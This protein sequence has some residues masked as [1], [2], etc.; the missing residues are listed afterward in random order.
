VN[1]KTLSVR[2]GGCTVGGLL[3]AEVLVL[4]TLG[5]GHLGLVLSNG[6]ELLI[7]IVVAFVLQQ[8]SRKCSGYARGIWQLMALSY[9]MY[10][11]GVA[12]FLYTLLQPQATY[13]YGWIHF[14]FNLWFTPLG[15]AIL[16]QPDSDGKWLNSTFAADLVQ[17]LIYSVAAYYYLAELRHNSGTSSVEN[18][19]Y[20]PYF[21]YCSSLILACF[22][23]ARTSMAP[24]RRSIFQQIGIWLFI[25]LLIG[26]ID[27]AGWSSHLA[28][29]FQLRYSLVM[30]LP[31][32]F[33]WRSSAEQL[34]AERWDFRIGRHSRIT[35]LLPL[36]YPLLIV[37]L[38]IT[39]SRHQ[40]AVAWIIVAASFTVSSARLLLIQD[41]L[42]TTRKTLEMQATHDYLTGLWNRG[43][44]LNI[45]EIE[46][47][48]AG[49]T[50][51]TVGV[52]MLDLDYF[53]SVN[54]IYGHA[55][56]D[57]LLQALTAEVA[58]SLRP[59]DSFGRYGGEE[60][61]IVA[62]G[63]TP[64][65]AMMLAERVREKI[66]ALRIPLLRDS[67][68]I[69]TSVGVVTGNSSNGVDAL[70]QLADMACYRAKEEGRNR[71]VNASDC[72]NA[73]SADFTTTSV[74][75]VETVGR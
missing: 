74:V 38:A 24:A 9:V 27:W 48:R 75:P 60:F 64:A 33:V 42:V 31:L 5:R 29:L 41:R 62:P 25:T 55:V 71:V 17:T 23:R 53:K 16:I 30:S 1:L 12:L 26:A 22:L 45:L 67:I 50:K 40:L 51:A 21:I 32:Y 47:Q 56:G 59:Y 70:L 20:I 66:A 36:M 44:L 63:C 19:S 7:A 28:P 35:L 69:T 37:L 6:I 52:I 46:L 10:G 61:L 13:P 57:R 54:D 58:D 39:L 73:N 72:G 18:A 34:S 65:D 3:A 4:S 11:L 8:M 68:G 49:H 43:A 14:L 15:L 2:S